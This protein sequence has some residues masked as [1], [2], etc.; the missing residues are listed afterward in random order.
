MYVTNKQ[1][2]IDD[3]YR[4]HKFYQKLPQKFDYFRPLPL[5]GFGRLEGTKMLPENP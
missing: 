4:L 2:K 5:T 3:P 1:F